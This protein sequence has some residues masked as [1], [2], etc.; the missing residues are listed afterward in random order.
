MLFL[1]FRSLSEVVIL[2]H[3]IL[4]HFHYSPSLQLC[5]SVFKISSITLTVQPYHTAFPPTFFFHETLLVHSYVGG[6]LTVAF[7]LN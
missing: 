5:Q 3:V 2:V 6:N 7:V 4:F 1:T